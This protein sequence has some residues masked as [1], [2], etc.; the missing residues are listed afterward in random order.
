M[1]RNSA[2][3]TTLLISVAIAF[4]SMEFPSRQMPL[5][6]RAMI[7]VSIPCAITWLLILGLSLRRF[8]K[9]A[10]WILVGGVFAFWWPVW[11]LFNRFPP[12]YYS[13]RC[14]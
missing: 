4:L 8:G 12:C 3:A 1:T 6:Y 7:T 10:L 2:Y 14:I 11:M 13:H 5:D 9:R